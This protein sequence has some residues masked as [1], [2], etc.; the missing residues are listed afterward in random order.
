MPQANDTEKA[1]A[2]RLVG[3]GD[4][5]F[6][7][8]EYEKALAAY[9]GADLIMGVPTTG[10]EVARCLM[11]LGR[12]REA[13]MAALSVLRYPERPGEPRAFAMA[14]QKSR[15]LVSELED[16]MGALRLDGD[17]THS[18]VVEVDGRVEQLDNG[19]IYV[20]AGSH[21]VVIKRG[22][23][24]LAEHQVDVAERAHRRIAVDESS[25]D[26]VEPL[27]VPP[28]AIVGFSV[29]SGAVVTG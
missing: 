26:D 9:R 19:I 2:R 10:F 12:L 22:D 6:A 27:L 5:L 17:D 23:A 3:V 13:R 28:V 29:A 4:D 7:T 20:D 14:R 1:T 8:G 18:L 25:S 24:V 16:R 21:R 11:I 15:A